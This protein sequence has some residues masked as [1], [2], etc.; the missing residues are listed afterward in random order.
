LGILGLLIVANL[1]YFG[2][3]VWGPSEPP[4]AIIAM[5]ALQARDD[6][7]IILVSSGAPATGA[8]GTGR[9]RSMPMS[10]YASILA[11]EPVAPPIAR[12]WG[13]R[14]EL[15]IENVRPGDVERLRRRVRPGSGVDRVIIWHESAPRAEMPSSPFAAGFGNDWDLLRRER[16]AVHD[17][18]MWLPLYDLHREVWTRRSSTE[19][20]EPPPL[21][22]E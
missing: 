8:P 17:H 4:T 21:L 13:A 5:D 19:V 16:W 9:V 14:R 12:R 15:Q 20:L 11:R 2:L 6:R 1:G 3:R 18:W 10:Y 7:A 22:P